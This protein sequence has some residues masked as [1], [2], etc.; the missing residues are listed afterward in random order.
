MSDSLLLIE[1]EEQRLAEAL[2][3]ANRE[4]Q[5]AVLKATK[6][7]EQAYQ[8]QVDGQAAFLDQQLRAARAQEEKKAG[9]EI[10]Y[11]RE[12]TLKEMASAQERV[13]AVV[14]AALKE[15]GVK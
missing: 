7:A 4:A 5:E 3:T 13:D 12:Q 15:L 10:A 1:K 14:Q 6:D 8:T 11:Q 2:A 9:D